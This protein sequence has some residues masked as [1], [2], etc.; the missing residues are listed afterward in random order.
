MILIPAQYFGIGDVIFEISLVRELAKE[1]NYKVVWPVMPEHVNALNFAY[2]DIQFVNY[3]KNGVDFPQVDFNR[4]DDHVNTTYNYRY[5][6][7]RWA[8]QILKVPYSMCMASKYLLY[9]K[10]W[11][12]WKQNVNWRRDLVKEIYLKGNILN[13]PTNEEYILVN[14]IYG[15]DCHLKRSITPKTNLRI[16]HMQPMQGVGIFDWCLTLQ[17][18]K[19][20]H[21]V[22]SSLLYLVEYLPLDAEHIAIHYRENDGH[23]NNVRYLFTKEYHLHE[24]S[25]YTHHK[26]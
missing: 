2:P 22:S 9:N 13:I 7:L 1:G 20:I 17:H 15:A 24:R 23:L 14:E 21:F 10:R 25:G 5:L 12:D 19:E 8:D 16:V 11:E 6:P 18:A 3:K 26:P 4:K